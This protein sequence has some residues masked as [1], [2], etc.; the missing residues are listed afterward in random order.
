[1]CDIRSSQQSQNDEQNTGP[2][3]TPF[4]LFCIEECIVESRKLLSNDGGSG[5]RG[6]SSPQKQH[7]ALVCPRHP[8]SDDDD[9]QKKKT[10]DLNKIT[11]DLLFLD[12]LDDEILVPTNLVRRGRLIGQGAFGFVFNGVLSDG[13]N[14]RMV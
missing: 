7:L 12:L 8:K 4:Y 1:M 13:G 6:V 10:P 11:P 9:E 3:A 2:Q 5:N 14:R